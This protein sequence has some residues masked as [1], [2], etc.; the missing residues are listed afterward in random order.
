GVAHEHEPA[1]ADAQRPPGQDRLRDQ[2]GLGL[3]Q[4]T[5]VLVGV[6]AIQVLAG[7]QAEH[8][9][10][11]ELQA[12]VRLARA[13]AG[14]GQVR[15]VGER[16]LEQRQV[17]ERHPVLPAELVQHP[18]FLGAER[19]LARGFRAARE[20][21]AEPAPERLPGNGGWGRRA[22]PPPAAAAAATVARL[23]DTALIAR[24]TL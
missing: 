1:E 4:L 22:Q 11:E 21:A 6:P 10:A 12:L 18:R 19:A 2:Q 13:L 8:R 15:A 5:L 3:R 17:L 14:D 16:Q 24:D 20:P 7:H 23:Y 9:V